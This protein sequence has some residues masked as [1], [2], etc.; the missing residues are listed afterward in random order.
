MENNNE[1]RELT[2]EELSSIAGGSATPGVRCQ[3]CGS[4]I[5]TTIQRILSNEGVF[6]PTCGLRNNFSKRKAEKA[7][8]I[9]AKVAEAQLKYDAD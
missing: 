7:L 9:Y 5:Q 8:K 1:Q 2:E 4:F 3:H 6:C